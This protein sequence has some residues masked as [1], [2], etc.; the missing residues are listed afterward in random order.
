[1]SSPWSFLLPLDP[2]SSDWVCWQL[3]KASRNNRQWWKLWLRCW[4]AIGPWRM[5]CALDGLWNQAV[6]KKDC[7]QLLADW[8]LGAL[9]SWR[10]FL[11][12]TSFFQAYGPKKI[13][14]GGQVLEAAFNCKQ[15]CS[16]ALW[17]RK[18]NWVQYEKHL[19]QI[20]VGRNAHPRAAKLGK[21]LL[22]T[23]WQETAS[24]RSHISY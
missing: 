8:K 5:D 15:F 22:T 12:K 1:M 16:T 2:E 18:S 19:W 13:Q 9:T 14:A 21:S 7:A 20:Q 3:W 24:G 17:K 6:E 10:P 23:I 4:F 11:L